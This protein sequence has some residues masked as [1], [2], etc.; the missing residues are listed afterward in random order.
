[1]TPELRPLSPSVPAVRPQAAARQ[2]MAFQEADPLDQSELGGPRP[3]PETPPRISTSGPETVTKAQEVQLPVVEQGPDDL[4]PLKLRLAE[5]ASA[6]P[7]IVSGT[8]AHRWAE[9]SDP[10]TR[11]LARRALSG[12]YAGNRLEELCQLYGP[13]EG[14]RQRIDWEARSSDFDQER[15]QL[16]LDRLEGGLQE[17]PATPAVLRSLMLLACKHLR[18]SREELPPEKR[19]KE[20]VELD[21]A[22]ASRACDLLRRH[23]QVEGDLEAALLQGPVPVRGL[24]LELESTPSASSAEA[25]IAA[26][27]ILE[28]IPVLN[29]RKGVERLKEFAVSMPE[30]AAEVALALVEEFTVGR[31]TDEDLSAMARLLADSR[32]S[33]PLAQLFQPHQHSLETVPGR[34]E[35]LG[36]QGR[37]ILDFC[38]ALWKISPPDQEQAIAQVGAILN[39]TS[40]DGLTWGVRDLLILME[41]QPQLAPAIA[42]ETLK[43]RQTSYPDTAHFAIFGSALKAGWKPDPLQKDWLTSWMVPAGTKEGELNLTRYTFTASA[44]KLA[45]SLDLDGLLL[46]DPKGQLLPYREAL[47]AHLLES[48]KMEQSFIPGAKNCWEGAADCFA[49]LAPEPDPALEKRLLDPIAPGLAGA[50]RLTDC[51]ART[52]NHLGVLASIP[53]TPET[54]ARLG[55]LLRS[56]LPH[57]QAWFEPLVDEA[58]NQ[59][60][61]QAM[62]G[63]QSGDLQERLAAASACVQ[64]TVHRGDTQE[65][66]DPFELPPLKAA[67]AM[68]NELPEADKAQVRLW[69]G[70][71]LAGQES[72]EKLSNEQ[73]ADFVLAVPLAQ[74]DPQLEDRLRAIAAPESRQMGCFNV[75]SNTHDQFEQLDRERLSQGIEPEQA[76]ALLARIEQTQGFVSVDVVESWARGAS[77]WAGELVERFGPQHRSEALAAFTELAGAGQS[78]QQWQTLRGILTRV[79][80][81]GLLREKSDAERFQRGLEIWRAARESG[82]VEQ[83]L[84]QHGVVNEPAGSG[85]LESSSFVAFGGALVRRRNRT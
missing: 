79:E 45:R 53:L 60:L 61:E 10:V 48:D 77:G 16:A 35:A 12:G 47:L 83:A 18:R 30:R 57:S 58:R 14:S 15:I 75:R 34:A 36:I 72:L 67:L 82:D 6:M 4:W 84:R 5:R 49:L 52:R 59:V 33:L 13:V 43:Q 46:A 63:L 26:R 8:G 50:G 19:E 65:Q 62:A 9:S 73:L 40:H 66:R 56:S 11:Y 68:V 76:L 7:E 74:G 23:G 80:L 44:L 78:E 42:G 31:P 54:K 64:H 69:L 21:R 24:K 25:R 27:Q 37:G 55:E 41:K 38:A 85:V 51:D 1:M 2:E 29:E 28:Q 39:N 22:L 3:G 17:E 32:K 81:A 70:S 20:P 71:R